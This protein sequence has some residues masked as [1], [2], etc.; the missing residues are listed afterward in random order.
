[1]KPSEPD[2]NFLNGDISLVQLEWK[3]RRYD[4]LTLFA[5][6]YL[7]VS[8]D[9]GRGEVRGALRYTDCLALVFSK[10]SV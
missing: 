10:Q 3:N 6:A 2:K 4:P 5:L 8:K 1:M 9:G 7:S